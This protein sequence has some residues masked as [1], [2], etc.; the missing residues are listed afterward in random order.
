MPES[1]YIYTIL[2]ELYHIKRKDH[3]LKLIAFMALCIHWF[4]PLVWLAFGLAMTDMEMSCDEA[5]LRQIG[6]SAKAEYSISLLGFATGKQYVSA[7]FLAFGEVNP[8]ARIKNVLKWKKPVVIFS[9]IAVALAIFVGVLCLANPKTHA[10][11]GAIDPMAK[12]DLSKEVAAYEMLEARYLF[13]P[14]E[15]SYLPE[16][17]VYK[18]VEVN[19]K[20]RYTKIHYEGPD[21][22]WI[23]LYV[24]ELYMTKDPQFFL[25]VD[26]AMY[27][28]YSGDEKDSYEVEASERG[29]VQVRV[30]KSRISDAPV[31]ESY[32]A[33]H[34]GENYVIQSYNIPKEEYNLLMENLKFDK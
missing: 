15:F 29:P 12:Y 9:V 22:A 32:F 13:R 1:E 5:V 24:A 28:V 6:E 30:Y 10:S 16:G 31:I 34:K 2:H 8:K 27:Q 20:D 11:E 7:T 19:A 18:S 25:K 3:V 14:I 17:V 26:D 4:N 23:D 33:G 21:T